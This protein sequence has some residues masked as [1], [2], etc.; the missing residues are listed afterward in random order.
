MAV[1]LL[2]Q[3]GSDRVVTFD[4]IEAE[5]HES[6]SEISDHPV[7][8][9]IN[10]TD[11]VRPLPDTFS[12][13]GFISNTPT[14]FNPHTGRGETRSVKLATVEYFPTPEQ[15]LTSPG[16]ALR[17]GGKALA[18]TLFPSEWSATVLSFP[19]FFDAV[20]ETYE[21]LLELRNNAIPIRLL[22]TVREYEDL[23]VV[24]FA[25]PRIIGQAEGASFNIDL[26]EL[27]IVETGVVVAP[28]VP[29]IP[30]GVP[31]KAKG[32]QTPKSPDEAAAE[33]TEKAKSIAAS[34]VDSGLPF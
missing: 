33:S 16:G 34:I 19:D 13:T 1:F 23:V 27:R 20:R 6:V 30:T 32:N 31:L 22:T 4:A 11:H 15:L 17:F 29:T 21:T 8:T 25:M 10:V 5:N 28:P 14:K 7:E 2:P 18:D 26:R 24:R 9:G 3:D 12:F